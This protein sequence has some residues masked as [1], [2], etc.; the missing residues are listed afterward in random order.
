MKASFV[1]MTLRDYCTLDEACGNVLK[2]NALNQVVCGCFS[3]HGFH[4]SVMI[5]GSVNGNV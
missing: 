1:Y 2:K 5:D 3:Y 4:D